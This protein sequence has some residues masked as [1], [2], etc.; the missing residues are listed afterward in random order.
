MAM[1]TCAQIQDELLLYAGDDLPADLADHVAQ[2]A[3]CRRLWSEL[4]AAA[5]AM[6][7]DDV[8]AP[9]PH[10]ALMLERDI[11]QRIAAAPRRRSL[12]LGGLLK[13]AAAV[14]LVVGSSL[15]SYRVGKQ[16]LTPSGM[17]G[18]D[19]SIEYADTQDYAAADTAQVDIDEST[20]SILIDDYTSTVG[21]PGERLLD[22]LTTEEMEYLQ[23][24]L[25]AEDLL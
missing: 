2:C 13:I 7:T 17:A 19:S 4:T 24:N 23:Q 1:M 12:P 5:A 16:H 18:I 11:L 25:K 6:G 14:V 10:A 21:E 20:I 9:D 8:F 3:E 22:D 15:I